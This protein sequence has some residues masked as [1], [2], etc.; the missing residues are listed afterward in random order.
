MISPWWGTLL[1][2]CFVVLNGFFVAAEF[3][4]VKVRGTRLSS[5]AKKGFA[6]ARLAERVTARLDSYLNAT[7][8]GITLSSLSLGWVGGPAVAALLFP[9]FRFVGIGSER[10][11]HTIAVVVASGMLSVMHI[12]LGEMVPKFIGIRAAER[13]AMAA[14]RPMIVF[15]TVFLPVLWIMDRLASLLLRAVGLPATDNPEGR[16]S[17]EEI[18][19]MLESE[20]TRGVLPETMRALITR[21]LRGADRPVR[22]AMIPRVDVAFLSAL[23]PIEKIRER[24]RETEF[25][26]LPVVE[27]DDLDRVIGYVHL[28]DLFFGEAGPA[29]EIKPIVRELVFVPESTT[30]GNL[31]QE[32]RLSRVHLAIVVDEYGG[33]SGLIT[34]EDLMEELVGEIHDEFDTEAAKVLRFEDGTIQIDGALALADAASAV[35]IDPPDVDSETLGGYVTAKLGRMPKA[36][37]RVPFGPMIAE[38]SIVRR[39]RV[40]QV[41][42][43]PG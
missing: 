41:V 37:D 34:L 6:R 7:Q 11:V 33:T 3:A 8:L 42:L 12:L 30:V 4:L 1:A 35:G 2:V 13:T 19:G 16:L 14:A 24:A 10:V 29:P 23:H 39:R 36:G 26:R 21:V 9:V 43:R 38:V 17:E 5:L 15:R 31:L 27:G 18:R 25:S 28:R 20:A 40:A 22:S 32:L